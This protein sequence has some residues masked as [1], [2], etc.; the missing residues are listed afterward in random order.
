MD[1]LMSA[2][3]R[4]RP[5]G[6]GK[7][8]RLS[9][10]ATGTPA[11]TGPAGKRKKRA[12]TTAAGTGRTRGG[13]GPG[14]WDAGEEGA[15]E[16]L[17]GGFRPPASRP[18]GPGLRL[19]HELETL[20]LPVSCHPLE[21]YRPLLESMQTVPAS[22]LHRHVGRRVRTVGW[23]V[24]GKT[25]LTHRKDPMEF[26][27]FEDAT[28]LYETTFFPRAYERFCHLMGRSRPYLLRGRV[29]EEFGAVSLNVEEVRFL[30]QD[31]SRAREAPPVPACPV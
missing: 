12:R 20:G 15:G 22:E 23:F 7:G 1:E 26:V 18:Y 31:S 16:A 21:L 19:R 8:G 11:A 25:V 5:R 28:T 4:E 9:K 2:E 24:T 27:S 29:E 13:A 14:L 17:S 10:Q 6:T 3:D 30:D